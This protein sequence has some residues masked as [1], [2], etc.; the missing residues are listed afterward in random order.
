MSSSNSGL[1]V[2]VV[3]LTI[4]VGIFGTLFILEGRKTRMDQ[5]MVE[6]FVLRQRMERDMGVLTMI[7]KEKGVLMR[8]EVV[9]ANSPE[10]IQTMIENEG[11]QQ[12]QAAIPKGLGGDPYQAAM[13]ILGMP[14]SPGGVYGA[15]PNYHFDPQTG[16]VYVPEASPGM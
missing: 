11:K 13:R 7:P 16:E 2:A 5:T 6:E 3:M 9:Y 4:I 8:H 1:T 14:S 12:Q 10:V 15:C